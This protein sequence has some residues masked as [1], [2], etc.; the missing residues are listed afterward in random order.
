[1]V[2]FEREDL[3][4]HLFAIK[5]E[6][7]FIVAEQRRANDLPCPTCGGDRLRADFVSADRCHA[8]RADA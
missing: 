2:E 6:A 1:M 4:P 5:A 8:P 3:W 7:A